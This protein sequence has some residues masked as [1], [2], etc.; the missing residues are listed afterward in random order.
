MGQQGLFVDIL[1][2][3]L[4]TVGGPKV[5]QWDKKVGQRPKM[6]QKN[7]LVVGNEARFLVGNE[8]F[9]PTKMG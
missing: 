9:W 4:P 5:G 6:G 8:L 7:A 3:T 2:Q 1:R